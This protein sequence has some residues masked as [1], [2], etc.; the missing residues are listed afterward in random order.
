MVPTAE[1]VAGFLEHPSQI[2]FLTNSFLVDK[3][4]DRLSN[5]TRQGTNEISLEQLLLLLPGYRLPK[6]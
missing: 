2:D 5:R 6:R 4:E 3:M 1:A